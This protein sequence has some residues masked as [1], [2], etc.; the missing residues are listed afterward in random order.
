VLSHGHYDHTG[1]LKSV[2]ERIGR[3]EMR[4]VAHPGVLDSKY[5]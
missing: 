3:Q 1:G 2:L 5:G 4:I